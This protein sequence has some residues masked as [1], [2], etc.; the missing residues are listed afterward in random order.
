VVPQTAYGSSSASDESPREPG[1]PTN[2]PGSLPRLEWKLFLACCMFF[3]DNC[4]RARTLNQKRTRNDYS[5]F[6]G[7]GVFSLVNSVLLHPL[8]F[9][10]SDRLVNVW[11]INAQSG[12]DKWPFSYP[13]FVDWNRENKVFDG[14]AL[15]RATDFVVSR[16]GDNAVHVRGATVSS[17]LFE[18][19]KTKPMIGRSFQMK[20][21]EPGALW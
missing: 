18:V 4:K 20:D 15:W 9:P 14:M 5:K 11:Q 2:P 13:D 3:Q 6:V 16:N 12:N 17:A 1:R 7:P 10:D 8:P 21:D 19:L